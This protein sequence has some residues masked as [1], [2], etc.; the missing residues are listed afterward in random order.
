MNDLD[1]CWTAPIYKA[2]TGEDFLGL[3]AVQANITDYLLPGIITTTPRAR[4]YAFYSW[5][6]VE[7]AKQHPEGWSLARFI[8][9]R[10]QIFALANLAYTS[11]ADNH[12]SVAGLT[13]QRKL[14]EH[15]RAHHNDK[16]IPLDV[17]LVRTYVKASWGGY[18]AYAGVVRALELVRLAEGRDYTLDVLPQGQVLAE[19]FATSIQR[20]EY[21][22]RREEYDTASSIPRSVLIQYG[23]KCHLG[24][25]AHSDDCRPVLQVL[26]AFSASD[27]LPPSDSDLS[28]RGNMQ[29]SLGLI[30]EMVSQAD[31]PFT[32]DSF[33]ESIAYGLCADYDHYRPS[34]PLKPFLA[35]WQM[36]QMREYYVYALYA[37]WVYFLRWL[38][39][40]GPE[41]L[42]G[43]HDHLNEQVDLA[44][45]S[46][47][48]DI[49]V[50]QKSLDEWL[51]VDWLGALLDAA[52]SPG[53][54]RDG[55]CRAFAQASKTPLNEHALFHLL[56]NASQDNPSAYVGTTWLLLSTLFL[57]LR[58]LQDVNR[59]D[60]WRWARAGGARRRP[61]A[62]FVR[63]MSD[64]IA[65]GDTLLQT[66]NWLY[67]DYIV[68]QHTLTALGKWR[69]RNTN[70]F[71]FNYDRGILEWVQNDR[72]GLSASRFKQAHDMLADLGLY[73]V[74]P[75]ADGRP[76]LT[77]LGR[78][79]LERVLESCGG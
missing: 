74:S 53:S 3:R 68:A 64:H 10:E 24:H 15:W 67:R 79:T 25:L 22:K 45:T 9:R 70:T 13:G 17:D 54:D 5:L 2:T 30:L 14:N 73:C 66:W 39:L 75:E 11:V 41:T 16:S 52:E 8:R 12:P 4:Y 33:R 76:E 59:G 38:H 57:R 42:G 7:Y 34:L 21:Y 29:G 43:F 51:L 40:N 18:N 20:T 55:R 1:P 32:E 23:S 56:R 72:T 28:K 65:A 71:H 31:G 50:P 48:M 69:Q 37:L 36:F 19:A 60:A 46:A 62:L 27:F 44:K 77:E 35:H 63:D 49:A 26:F 47:A 78:Q 61:M 6:L 58:G